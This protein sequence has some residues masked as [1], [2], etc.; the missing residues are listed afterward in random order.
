[1]G[2][3]DPYTGTAVGIE[4]LLGEREGVLANGGEVDGEK[5]LLVPQGLALQP[6]PVAYP[7]VPVVRYKTN[8]WRVETSGVIL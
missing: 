1:M 5:E 3:N 6:A 7:V 4:L 2:L 8:S